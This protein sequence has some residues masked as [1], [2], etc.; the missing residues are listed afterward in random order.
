MFGYDESK[1]KIRFP[2]S[3][4]AFRE[5]LDNHPRIRRKL[6]RCI[7]ERALDAIV[8]NAKYK[9]DGY[10]YGVGT[11]TFDVLDER[12]NASQS[13]DLPKWARSVV[14]QYDNGVSI[15]ELKF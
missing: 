13:G 14:D 15:R 6:G 11:S 2:L 7:L 12:G 9:G 10:R 4:R 8:P 1:P 5:F 3:R